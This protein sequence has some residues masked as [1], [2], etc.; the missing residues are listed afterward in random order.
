MK[1]L[2]MC[3]LVCERDRVRGDRERAGGHSIHK[4]CGWGG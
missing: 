1:I 4:A 3:S 2:K